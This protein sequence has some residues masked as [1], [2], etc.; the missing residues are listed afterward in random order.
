M[1]SPNA[2]HE[3]PLREPVSRADNGASSGSAAARPRPLRKNRRRWLGICLVAILI[4][5]AIAAYWRWPPGEKEI[6]SQ[7][8]PPPV[9]INTV[10]TRS[11]DIGVYVQAEVS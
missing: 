8:G 9:L 11:G 10:T 7:G 4:A 1:N 5:G 3:Q 2:Q 6:S